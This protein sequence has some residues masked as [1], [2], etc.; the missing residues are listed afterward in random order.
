MAKGHRSKIKAERNSLKDE[1]AIAKVNF[2]RLSSTKAK[3][4]LDQIKGKDVNTALSILRYTPRYAADVI[5]KVVKSAAA[6]AEHNNGMN[7]TRLFIEEAFATQGPTLKRIR[8]RAQGRAYRIN[9]NTSHI[10][11]ILNER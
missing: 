11:V 8:P 10:T 5:E 4:V 2:A 1:R 7:T 6:N 3:I 9:K